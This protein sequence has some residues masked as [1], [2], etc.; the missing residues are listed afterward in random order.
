[1]SQVVWTRPQGDRHTEEQ[2]TRGKGEGLDQRQSESG[3]NAHVMSEEKVACVA[4]NTSKTAAETVAAHEDVGGELSLDTRSSRKLSVSVSLPQHDSN[5]DDDQHLRAS[6]VGTDLMINTSRGDESIG[7]KNSNSLSG[8]TMRKK[9]KEMIETETPNWQTSTAGSWLHD[10]FP[11]DSSVSCR[12]GFTV[13]NPSRNGLKEIR[14]TFKLHVVK[15]SQKVIDSNYVEVLGEGCNVYGEFILEGKI[16]AQHGLRM[17]CHRRYKKDL[18]KRNLRTNKAK[19]GGNSGSASHAHVLTGVG[20]STA[21]SGD[22]HAASPSA[23]VKTQSVVA[24]DQRRS[25]NRITLGV[26][27]TPLFSDQAAGEGGF[28][29]AMPVS[30]TFAFSSAGK[31]LKAAQACN[32]A[33]I[34]RAWSKWWRWVSCCRVMEGGENGVV[35]ENG[36]TAGPALTKGSNKRKISSAGYAHPPCD[37]SG[38]VEN[39]IQGI[40]QHTQLTRQQLQEWHVEQH[41]CDSRR[42]D[43]SNVEVPHIAEGWVSALADEDGEV[44]EGDVVDGERDGL[45]ICFFPNGLLYQGRWVRGREHGRGKLMTHSRR[46]I[47]EGEWAEG[48]MSGKGRYVFPSGGIYEGDWRENVRQGRGNYHLPEGASYDGDWREDLRWGFGVFTWANGSM[49]E[50]EWVRGLRQG[51]GHLR[52]PEFEYIG[53]WTDNKMEGKG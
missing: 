9:V 4:D 47:Y 35:T 6:H 43:Q 33:Q 53:Q 51:K 34:R 45:G 29:L 10:V 14:E 18:L 38:S 27:R 11:S 25:S 15:T 44:Y 8:D 3:T 1:V 23:E 12:G 40:Q 46:L 24:L 17:I 31:V 41:T 30:A 49:Y 36:A 42:T 13:H 5:A 26:R 16:N 21:P 48:K 19:S 20:P 7:T 52:C 32:R 2:E 22:K 50:G 37:S 39:K 28:H